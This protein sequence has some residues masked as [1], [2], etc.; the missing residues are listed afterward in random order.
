MR[1]PDG[2]GL[3]A[4]GRAR[5]EKVL[6]QAAQMFEQ[7]ISPVQVACRLRVST[8]LA[9]QWRRRWRS[10]G[11]AAL[12]SKGVGGMVRR[13]DQAQLARRCA[14][15]DKGPAAHGRGE[16]QRWTLDREW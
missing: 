12:V 14:G 3:S 2:G 10:G 8:K 11:Q 9:Y 1:Y 6:L 7:E 16:D 5:P 13:L 4:V 15:L